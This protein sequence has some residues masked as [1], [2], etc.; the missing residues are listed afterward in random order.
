[1]SIPVLENLLFGDNVIDSDAAQVKRHSDVNPKLARK[2]ATRRRFSI[3]GFQRQSTPPPLEKVSSKEE[4]CPSDL[5][6]S[7]ALFMKQ[8]KKQLLQYCSAL[9]L[10]KKPDDCSSLKASQSH[11]LDNPGDKLR[12]NKTIT[13]ADIG[14]M[15]SE[16]TIQED[17]EI[18][19]PKDDDEWMQ[20]LCGE[21]GE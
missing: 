1:M 12:R 21:T 2:G 17:G 14:K 15:K 8:K 9:S 18:G 16:E 4:P 10:N 19:D 13:I 5:H 3:A 11:S 7:P 6:E 20:F